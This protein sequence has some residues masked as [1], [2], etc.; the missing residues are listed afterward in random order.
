MRRKRR[1]ADRY[2]IGTTQKFIHPCDLHSDPV[3]KPEA[4][5][6]MTADESVQALIQ[7]I[8]VVRDFGNRHVS[9]DKIID[10]FDGE[11]VS[12]DGNDHGLKCVAQ[13]LF[14]QK[15]L[16]PFEQFAFGLI[17]QT[18]ALAGFSRY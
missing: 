5:P 3:A 2:K 12:P 8:V 6:G 1:W 10:Q 15:H 7:L 13:M 11:S 17:C 16:F 18:L 4:L 14:Y 9:L